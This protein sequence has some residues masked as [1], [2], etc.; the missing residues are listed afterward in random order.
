MKGDIVMNKR[1]VI[2]SVSRRSGIDAEVCRT[3]LDA[4]EEV[5]TDEFAYNN[6][7]GSKFDRIYK[8]MTFLKG[9]KDAK[10]V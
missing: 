6:G 5:L 10:K 4:F 1:D 3:V 9:K 2:N 8:I 7:K